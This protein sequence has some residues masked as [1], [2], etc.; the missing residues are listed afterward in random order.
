MNARE[1]FRNAYENRYTW[2]RNFP[3]YTTE[4][5]FRHGDKMTK[6]KARVNPDLSVDVL[7]ADDEDTEK[8]I[9]SQLQE[10]AIH[11]I[12]RTFEETHAKNEFEIG[13]TDDT[14]AVEI[15]V[16]GKSSGNR[17]KV[18]DNEVCHVHR[19]IHGIVVTIDTFSS[20]DTGEGYLSHRYSSI[21]RDPKTGEIKSPYSEFEDNYTKVGDYFILTSRTISTEGEPDTEFGFDRVELLQPAAVGA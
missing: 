5:T 6:A 8:A 11:R 18:R 1:L 2:D 3:G 20:H 16:G 17:Y 12:R 9:A 19:H 21:Y 4:A 10:V 15:H 14:G 13:E 7:E